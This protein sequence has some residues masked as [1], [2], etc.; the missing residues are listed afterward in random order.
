MHYICSFQFDSFYCREWKN[1]FKTIG[2]FLGVFQSVYTLKYIYDQSLAEVLLSD[3]FQSY[4]IIVMTS[5]H[6][7]VN[8]EGEWVKNDTWLSIAT[9]RG[10]AMLMWHAL[11]S[12]LTAQWLAMAAMGQSTIGFQYHS[13]VQSLIQETEEIQEIPLWR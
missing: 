5:W 1:F 8:G 13:S 12:L 11:V 4:P 2:L 9:L 10:L 6:I 3:I 7:S